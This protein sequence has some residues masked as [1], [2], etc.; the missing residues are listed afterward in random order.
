MSELTD[1]QAAFALA[2]AHLILHAN[3]LGY[4]VRFGDCYRDPRCPYGHPQSAHRNRLAVD[5]MLDIRNADGEWVWQQMSEPYAPLGEWWEA[6]S[7]QYNAA[8]GG[9]FQPQDGVHF[10]FSWAGVK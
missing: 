1:R 10:S 7:R 9:R 3:R 4:R 8:W 5:L 6:E 2:T